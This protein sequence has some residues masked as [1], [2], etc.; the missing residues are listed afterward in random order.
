MS[1]RLMAFVGLIVLVV[2]VI[3]L[4]VMPTTTSQ[5]RSAKPIGTSA[6]THGIN[7]TVVQP[8]SRMDTSDAVSSREEA[9]T[10]RK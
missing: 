2:G 5:S 1:L 6:V 4:W 7:S 10:P 8:K 3:V 9:G